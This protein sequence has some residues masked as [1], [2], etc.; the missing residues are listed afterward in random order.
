MADIKKQEKEAKRNLSGDRD[1]V[2][3]EQ[4]LKSKKID[5]ANSHIGGPS[6]ET[7]SIYKNP[8]VEWQSTEKYRVA[9]VIAPAWGVLF[10]PYNIAKLTGLLRQDGF[11]VKVYDVNIESYHHVKN[12]TGEDYWRGER[13]FYWMFKDN[14]YNYIFPDIQS[15]L[16]S[17]VDDIVKSNPKVI[18]FSLY[19]TN[20]FASLYMAKKIRELLPDACLLA[21]GPE[22][23]T[24][25]SNFETGREA[26]GIF[27]YIFVGESE[28]NLLNLLNDLPEQ[29]PFNSVVGSIVSRLELDKYPFPDYSDYN[30][31]YYLERGISM[32]T[33]R[34]CVAQCSFCSET[35]F[36]KFRSLSP[37]RI[38]EEIEYQVRKHNIVRVW[39]V[40]SLINGNL[41]NFRKLVDLL[42]EKSEKYHHIYWNSYAR[43]DGRMEAE[44]F[45]KIKRSGGTTLS[46]GV[47]SG[48]QKVLDDM[49]KK[50]EIWEIENNLKDSKNAGIFT[51]VNWII[52]FATEEAVDHFHSMQLI[53]NA[54]KWIDAISPG[55]TAGIAQYSHSQTDFQVYGIAGKESSWDMVFLNQWYTENFKNTIIHRFIRLKFFHIWLDI[56]KDHKGSI[57]QNTQSFDNIKEFYTFSFKE[58]IDIDYLEQDFNVEFNQQGLG[59]EESVFAEYVGFAYLL[60]LY[61]KDFKIKV[62]F[63]REKDLNTFGDYLARNYDSTFEFEI[64]RKRQFTLILNH[65]LDDHFIKRYKFSGNIK[66]WKTKRPQIRETI[67]EQYRKK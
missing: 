21:G 38:V 34:G 16:D 48:S 9:M 37:E 43:C 50:I 6:G 22:T 32:E 36:W 15:L 11:S 27:N 30:L 41:K 65:T 25:Q 58:N 10:P 14:F 54:R 31:E 4:I 7:P 47:E 18:G 13:Y 64:N 67:H 66:D 29:L 12:K 53:Y 3:L 28:E 39:F 40:D 42:I 8:E 57:I 59:F 56:L 61:F 23:I 60:S 63:N 19:N 52:G 62:I 20:I 17:E 24:G 1:Q 33:S 44:F 45:Q 51:H 35:Y 2:I 5:H 46:F 26:G 55:A 49:R